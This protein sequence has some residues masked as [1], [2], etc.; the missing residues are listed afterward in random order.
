MSKM[1]HLRLVAK[2][3]TGAGAQV[4]LDGKPLTCVAAVQI[5]VA[6]DEVNT[7]ALALVA[8]AL[9]ID[10]EGIIEPLVDVAD[11]EERMAREMYEKLKARFNG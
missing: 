1:H 11:L 7:A 10:C 5:N 6:M 8:P 4:L 9:E 2:A 3:G